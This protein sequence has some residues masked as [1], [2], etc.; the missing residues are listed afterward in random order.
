MTTLIKAEQF[1]LTREPFVYYMNSEWFIGWG[2]T[3]TSLFNLVSFTPIAYQQVVRE[4]FKMYRTIAKLLK[5][6]EQ[7]KNNFTNKEKMLK[8]F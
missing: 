6:Q 8:T 5:L 3:K 2:V 1:I 4:C 7:I